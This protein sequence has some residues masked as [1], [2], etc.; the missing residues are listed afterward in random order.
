[1]TE[2]RPPY[3]AFGGD[4]Y[5]LPKSRT[6]LDGLE[7]HYVD[8]TTSRDTVL[9]LPILISSVSGEDTT[10]KLCMHRISL[11]DDLLCLCN[12]DAA[13]IC[14]CCGFAVC[15]GHTSTR[16]ISLPNVSGREPE[17][18]LLCE[19]CE[20]FSLE[21][22]LAF[23]AFRRVANH[24]PSRSIQEK[25]PMYILEEEAEDE[26]EHLTDTDFIY[27]NALPVHGQPASCASLHHLNWILRSPGRPVAVEDDDVD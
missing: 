2:Y 26:I 19:T 1:M 23:R 18:Q 22:I 9:F 27:P 21:I 3:H 6:H 11:D 17:G 7:Q 14:P 24:D 25:R 12:G 15:A 16:T 8:G 20:V 5:H 13:S 4:T 10:P